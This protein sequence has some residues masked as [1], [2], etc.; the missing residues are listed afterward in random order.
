MAK[1]VRDLAGLGVHDNTVGVLGQIR[2]GRLLQSVLEEAFDAR[3]HGQLDRGAGDGGDVGALAAGDLLAVPVGLE[4]LLP[5][6]AGED[7]VEAEL[8]AGL[9]VA[10]H[11]GEAQKLA[12]QIPLGVVPLHVGVVADGPI[13][14][15]GDQLGDD[16]G[17]HLVLDLHLLI[18][19]A[20]PG[21]QLGHLVHD[22][23]VVHIEQGGEDVGDTLPVRLLRDGLGVHADHV[24]GV[25][26]RKHVAVAVQYLP[27][28]RLQ[29][30][31]ALP[32]ALGH[33]GV[34][35]ALDDGHVIEV[36]KNRQQQEYS[37][38]G[39]HQQLPAKAGYAGP[40]RHDLF[41]LS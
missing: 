25:A 27:A 35:R 2:T 23:L 11:V 36:R 28:L 16:V 13:L 41:S 37:E 32:L 6:H 5:V 19:L 7:G 10:V 1:F 4:D 20:V 24:G 39:S 22:G 15:E 29:G 40:P 33:A 12:E 14:L 3:V 17:L 31:G 21:I 9:A 38:G 26:L 34:L 18:G 30:Q 8:H